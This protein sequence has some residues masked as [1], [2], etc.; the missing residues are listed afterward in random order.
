MDAP[1]FVKL[2]ED[3]LS[4]RRIPKGEFYKKSG[5]SSATFSQ[6]RKG[7]YS[8]SSEN[9]RRIEEYLG[10]KFELGTKE[11]P[12][13]V[14]G[15]ELSEKDVQLAN[16]FRSLS[17]EKQRALLNLGDAPKELLDALEN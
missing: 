2:I 13:T 11:K 6:W 10:I 3:E 5:V 12:A 9:I 4:V 8:P 17:A 1:A 14:A 16:W 7:T 15:D